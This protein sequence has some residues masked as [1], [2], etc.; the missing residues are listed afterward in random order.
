[1]ALEATLFLWFRKILSD[2]VGTNGIL[3]EGEGDYRKKNT[4]K[5]TQLIG[6]PRKGGMMKTKMISDEVSP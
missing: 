1:M 4:N 6:N 2:T 5:C 3:K